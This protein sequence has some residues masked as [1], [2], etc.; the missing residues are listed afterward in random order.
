MAS[1]N[2]SQSIHSSTYQSIN[3][4]FCPSFPFQNIFILNN[5]LLKTATSELSPLL[6]DINKSLTHAY[7]ISIS[8][9]DP[10]AHADSSKWG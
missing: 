3:L 6:T 8:S 4:A 1:N 9:T 2:K 10:E 7:N 5:F